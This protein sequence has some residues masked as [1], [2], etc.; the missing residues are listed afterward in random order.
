MLTYIRDQ[1]YLYK[2]SQDRT[3]V[4]L[5]FRGDLF[6]DTIVATAILE[7]LLHHSTTINIK[8]YSYRIKEKKQAGFYDVSKFGQ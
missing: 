7:R 1:R 2:I 4:P 6:G 8:G 3:T 5:S